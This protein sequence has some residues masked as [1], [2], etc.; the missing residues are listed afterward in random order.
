MT[1]IEFYDKLKKHFDGF[2]D[3]CRKDGEYAL[4]NASTAAFLQEVEW[5]LTDDMPDDKDD[6]EPLY[7]KL[8][9]DPQLTFRQ[10]K[11][12]PRDDENWAEIFLTGSDTAYW[13]FG[14]LLHTLEVYYD[15]TH[16][17]DQKCRE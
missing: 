8:S 10:F 17:E 7:E 13:Y 9:K 5:R 1:R 15:E 2:Y 16:E 11:D 3:K 14:S 12:T 4:R 6:D